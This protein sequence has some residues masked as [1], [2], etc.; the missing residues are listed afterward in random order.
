MEIEF[1][2]HQ[3]RR[4]FETSDLA[5]RTWGSKIG[6][7]YIQRVQLIIAAR[8]LRD[9]ETPI[10]LHLHSLTGRREGQ[11]AINL[12]ERWRLVFTHREAGQTILIEEVSNHYDD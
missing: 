9:L 7:K 2:T 12:D 3:L 4:C 10:S 6:R 5:S 8:T 1:A 11:W